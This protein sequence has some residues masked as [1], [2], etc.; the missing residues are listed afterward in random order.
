MNRRSTRVEPLRIACLGWGS[1]VWDP[2]DLPIRREWFKDGPFVPVEFARLSDDNRITLV[3]SPAATPIRVLWAHMVPT[4]LSTARE[5]L[6]NREGITARNWVELVGAWRHGE[7][8][9]DQIPELPEWA[10]QRGVGAVVWTALAPK[11]KAATGS[12]SA[13][14]VIEHL[15]GLRGTTREHAKQ[16]IERAP[17]QV[18]TE[19][20]RRIEAVF[21]WSIKEGGE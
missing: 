15:R 20:R 14:E 4:D 13:D 2:R 1:L 17:R 7:A 12:P 19:Y 18:D 11:L 3:I 21:G 5:A 6:R 8:A 9:P 10:A 16:Y